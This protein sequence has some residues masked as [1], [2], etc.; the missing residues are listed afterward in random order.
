MKNS[1]I[2]LLS[3]RTRG[4]KRVERNIQKKDHHIYLACDLGREGKPKVMLMSLKTRLR[5]LPAA[6]RHLTMRGT[7]E[8]KARS[9][10]AA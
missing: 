2:V 10:T 8:V 5:E 7:R 9:S 3:L 1:R 4:K 6:R